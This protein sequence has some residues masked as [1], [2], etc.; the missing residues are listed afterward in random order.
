[1]KSRVFESP[2]RTSLFL[3]LGKGRLGA[4]TEGLLNVLYPPTALVAVHPRHYPLHLVR[5][6][7]ERHLNDN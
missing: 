1:M 3:E 5:E 7:L 2:E 6:L 4:E